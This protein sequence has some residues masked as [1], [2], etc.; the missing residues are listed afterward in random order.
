MLPYN[1]LFPNL[2][3]LKLC[4][5]SYDRLWSVTLKKKI[6]GK[7]QADHAWFVVYLIQIIQSWFWSFHKGQL[8][9][10]TINFSIFCAVRGVQLFIKEITR[11]TQWRGA[12]RD[13]VFECIPSGGISRIAKCDSKTAPVERMEHLSSFGV[14][15]ECVDLTESDLQFV[16]VE[17]RQG[18][19]SALLKQNIQHQGMMNHNAEI[20]P[21]GQEQTRIGCMAWCV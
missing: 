19:V 15:A 1:F 10:S 16:W 9:G 11:A 6:V 17:G 5:I 18:H 12:K 20:C 13:R 7:L 8:P 3:F 21:F 14:H 4:R 2:S